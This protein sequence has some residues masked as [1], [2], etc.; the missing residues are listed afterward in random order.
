M[1]SLQPHTGWNLYNYKCF[2]FQ[3]EKLDDFSFGVCVPIQ[4][5]LLTAPKECS[6]SWQLIT[7]GLNK[8][9]SY[10]H[11]QVTAKWSLQTK[12]HPLQNVTHCKYYWYCMQYSNCPDFVFCT[13]LGSLR[14]HMHNSKVKLKTFE[15]VDCSAPKVAYT[16]VE[17]TVHLKTRN[18]GHLWGNEVLTELR[19]KKTA[20]YKEEKR[21][22]P[23]LLLGQKNIKTHRG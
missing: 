13:T 12:G 9:V 16:L 22:A 10:V 21:T 15:Y 3:C 20:E 7:W 14:N 8:L 1:W 23:F 11:N 2:N 17:L 19:R 5:N 4:R 18:I 6:F